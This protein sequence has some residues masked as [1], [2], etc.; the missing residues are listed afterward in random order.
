LVKNQKGQIT[1]EFI[2]I[3]IIMLIFAQT[4]I[5]PNL[6]SSIN[7]IKDVSSLAYAR[8]AAKK[9]ADAIDFL[10]LNSSD[11]ALQIEIF[12]P[13]NTSLRCDPSAKKIFFSSKI[14]L[15]HEACENDEDAN[16]EICTKS[17]PTISTLT[18]NCNAFGSNN[19]LNSTKNSIYKISIRRLGDI[20][21]VE[22]K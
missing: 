7:S 18:F 1:I 19:T 5:L 2:L 10:S 17:I 4:I 3:L 20:I 12:L 15:P 22:T 9:I 6:F 21:Y 11:S 13:A 16:A 8:N 14:L